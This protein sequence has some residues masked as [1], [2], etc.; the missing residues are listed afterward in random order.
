MMV[1]CTYVYRDKVKYNY[2]D[3]AGQEK[4]RSILNLY[5]KGSDA[6]LLVYSVDSLKSFEE[7]D[8]YYK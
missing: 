8:Y 7:L 3:T 5:F 6:A 1:D 2:Y 4:Y